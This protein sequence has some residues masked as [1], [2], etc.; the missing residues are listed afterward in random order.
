MA[1]A[2]VALA[3]ADP[4][5]EA[6]S[7]AGFFGPGRYTDHSN[8]DVFPAVVA[9]FVFFALHFVLRARFVSRHCGLRPQA[10]LAAWT[11]ALDVKTIAL[12]LPAI[13]ALQI[14]ALYVT[15]TSEQLIVLGHGLGGTVWFGA[16]V[17][18]SLAIH[19]TLCV[20]T[21]FATARIVRSLA[22]PALRFVQ[23]VTPPAARLAREP[24]LSLRR[25]RFAPARLAFAP[26]VC[27]LRSSSSACY[28]PI[29]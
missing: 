15:E 11:R 25:Y 12:L 28:R 2:F 9:G 24:S 4:L 22:R 5:A 1:I 16:P 21:T 6:A 7:N 13:F 14:G 27:R 10:W 18:V 3:L 19:A 23:F 20:A 29:K 26:I 8:A 17:L